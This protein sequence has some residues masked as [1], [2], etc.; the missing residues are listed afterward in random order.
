MPT[1]G[2]QAE[3]VLPEVPGGYKTMWGVITE[4]VVNRKV[5]DI[6]LRMKGKRN[7]ISRRE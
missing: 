2:D 1:P 6:P 3:M 7:S 4:M 5:F